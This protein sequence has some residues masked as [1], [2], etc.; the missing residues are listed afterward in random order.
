M[1]NGEFYLYSFVEGHGEI[2]AVPKLL[3]R[4]WGGELPLLLVNKPHRIPRDKFIND[5]GYR[6]NLLEIARRRVNDAANRG[7]LILL[8]AE[9]ECCQKFLNGEKMAAVRS[10]IAEILRD[11]PN[12][13]VLA[14]KEYES[15]LVAGMGGGMTATPEL[16]IKK[17]PQKTGLAGGRYQKRIDQAKLTSGDKFNAELAARENYSFRRFRERVL[18]LPGRRAP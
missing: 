2:S 10:D 14:E 4:I 18:A 13:L 15:W 11:I 12:L 1:N 5:S 7:V 16:W 8:D 3:H 9:E 6:R 17:N